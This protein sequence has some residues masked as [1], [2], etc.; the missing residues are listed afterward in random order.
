MVCIVMS[1]R[2]FA[3]FMWL[4]VYDVKPIRMHNTDWKV[5]HLQHG[6]YN[7][8]PPERQQLVLHIKRK[9]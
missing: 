7:S 2:Q 4:L 1:Q 3:L 9:F 5:V 8:F 6:A